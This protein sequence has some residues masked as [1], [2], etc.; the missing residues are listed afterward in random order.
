MCVNVFLVKEKY[1]SGY[2][3]IYWIKKNLYCCILLPLGVHVGAPPDIFPPCEATL[4]RLTC[5]VLS[6]YSF[7][8]CFALYLLPYFPKF[9]KFEISPVLSS[10]SGTSSIKCELTALWCPRFYL[11]SL[12][13]CLAGAL[14]MHLTSPIT[15][16]AIFLLTFVSVWPRIGNSYIVGIF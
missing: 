4:S 15:S 8:S 1:G 9:L 2:I 12:R 13:F 10:L 3:K 7:Y 6:H 11:F 14:L 5:C 16:A